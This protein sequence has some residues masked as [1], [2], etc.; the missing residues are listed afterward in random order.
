M[1]PMKELQRALLSSVAE[2]AAKYGFDKRPRGQTFYKKTTFGRLAFG[3][4]FIRHKTD[5]DVTVHVAI[6]FDE[7]E[8]L[9]NEDSSLLS[10]AEKRNTFSL[11]AE[12]G[13]IS[14]GRQKRWTVASPD[15]TSGDPASNKV[16]RISGI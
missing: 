5:F 2:Q 13:N 10:E 14:E 9:I 16:E 4:S 7:L 3:L 11:G 15:F 1:N 6:R 12:L 8:D